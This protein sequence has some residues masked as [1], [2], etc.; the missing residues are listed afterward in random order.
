[1]TAERL[2]GKETWFDR[3]LPDEQQAEERY[4]NF[5]TFEGEALKRKDLSVF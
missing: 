5:R 2:Q 1:V 4:P 3:Q